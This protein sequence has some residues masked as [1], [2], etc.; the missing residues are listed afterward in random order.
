[1]HLNT[2]QC[3]WPQACFGHVSSTYFFFKVGGQ[4]CHDLS[5]LRCLLPQ[6]GSGPFSNNSGSGFLTTTDYQNILKFANQ[7]H[8]QV[9]PEFDFPGHSHAAVRAMEARYQFYM[10]AGNRS[11][12]NEFRLKDPDDTSRYLSVQEFNDNAINPCIESTYRF[13]EFIVKTLVELHRNIQSLHTFHFGGDEV[14]KGAWVGS[15]ACQRLQANNPDLK[16][17][18]EWKKFFAQRVS[19]IT[20]RY[21]ALEISQL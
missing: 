2:F 16:G 11:A 4:R 12:A 7:H 17:P 19:R 10:N 14:A 3:I 21:V 13:I 6:L 8:V 1:M 20:A 18:R 9:I 15:P 5:E